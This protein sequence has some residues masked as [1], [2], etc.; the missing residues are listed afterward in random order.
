MKFLKQKVNY[1]AV[2]VGCSIIL[3]LGLFGLNLITI[4][5]VWTLS[6]GLTIFG[7]MDQ[8]HYLTFNL[9]ML[10]FTFLYNKVKPTK[11]TFGK[12]AAFLLIP[13]SCFWYIYYKYNWFLSLQPME[14][15]YIVSIMF[16]YF[17]IL[18]YIA[19]EFD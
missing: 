3:V 2:S 16:M 10:Y 12:T 13:S 6:M 5:I 15:H 18:I 14:E 19:S 7:Y 17:Y 4:W 9:T 1:L 11:L 8:P